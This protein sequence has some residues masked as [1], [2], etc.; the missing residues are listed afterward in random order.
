MLADIICSDVRPSGFRSST[1]ERRDMASAVAA[2]VCILAL[3][4]AVHVAAVG[5]ED[6]FGWN[7]ERPTAPLWRA[8]QA[9][10]VFQGQWFH[11]G[12][13][14]ASPRAHGSSCLD[15][16]W[17]YDTTSQKW[18][19]LPSDGHRPSRTMGTSWAS[20][21]L[22]P[23]CGPQIFLQLAV[24]GILQIPLGPDG[25]AG[26]NMVAVHRPSGPACRSGCLLYFSSPSAECDWNVTADSGLHVHRYDL[27]AQ[28]WRRLEWEDDVGPSA[29]LHAAA[30]RV[31]KG[32]RAQVYV[33]GGRSPHSGPVVALR[34]VWQVTLSAGEMDDI[35]YG[36]R[37]L[38][39][40][41]RTQGGSAH[42]YT[43]QCNDDCG[44]VQMPQR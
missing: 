21:V 3:G 43:D 19:Q 10:A 16:L 13:Y 32:A 33:V 7:I 36:S 4:R 17:A 29:R 28:N 25:F 42:G 2:F 39:H 30:A 38:R 11:H 6:D 23:S 12:G 44:H 8:F 37:L 26:G 15:D 34:D 1:L 40:C 41:V 5:T 9:S 14:S 18:T 31:G 35:P 27:G 20:H 22:P 24:Q